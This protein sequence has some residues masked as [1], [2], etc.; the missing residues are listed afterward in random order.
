MEDMRVSLDGQ[1]GDGAAEENDQILGDVEWLQTGSGN[2]VIVGSPGP[3]GIDGWE[4]ND[5]ISGGSGND[6]IAG[7]EGDDQLHGGDPGWMTESL[8]DGDDWVRG[9]VGNDVLDG[10]GGVDSLS[11]DEDDDRLDSREPVGAPRGAEETVAC[12]PGRDAA[13]TDAQDHPERCEV[14]TPSGQA[15]VFGPGPGLGPGPLV[16]T[17]P[18]AG[19][20]VLKVSLPRGSSRL[21]NGS[22]TFNVTCRSPRGTCQGAVTLG[23][24]ARASRAVLG[25]KAMRLTSGRRTPVRLRL[26]ARGRKMVSRGRRVHAFLEVTVRAGGQSARW[27]RVIDIRG[28]GR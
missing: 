10:G 22:L 1:P 21:R 20:P 2:D 6:S 11:G 26:G 19:P 14:V 8:L 15:W 27:V 12:G 24:A 13:E 5:V 28:A 4:G 7:D 25:R 17:T 16:G 3:D 9:G 18:P 23:S